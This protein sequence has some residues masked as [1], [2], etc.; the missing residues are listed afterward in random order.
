MDATSNNKK[1]GEKAASVL[2]T[3]DSGGPPTAS[4]SCIKSIVSMLTS[5]PSTHFAIVVRIG[6]KSTIASG[7]AKPEKEIQKERS[8]SKKK[9]TRQP[10]QLYC[11][12][13]RNDKPMIHTTPLKTS[14]DSDIS[15]CCF[16]DILKR[17]RTISKEN[18]N[19]HFSLLKY[20]NPILS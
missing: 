18:G 19:F 11:F 12:S 5:A 10:T 1:G 6:S 17:T 15:I 8:R 14:D 20:Q 3:M 9:K 16:T 4:S 7:K 2:T 13:R